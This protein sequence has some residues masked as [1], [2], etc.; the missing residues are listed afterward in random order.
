MSTATPATG[1]QKRDS[2]SGAWILDKT[3]GTW[4]MKEYLETMEVDPLAIEAH[5]KGDRE[6]DTIHT[7]EYNPPSIKIV[8]RSRVN[9]D[10]TTELELGVELVEYLN[11]GERPKRLLATSQGP[12]HLEIKST[13]QTLS[14]GVAAVTDVKQLQQEENSTIMIQNLTITNEK[15][16]KS[17]SM[18]RYF[19]PYLQ[20]PPHLVVDDAPVAT[21]KAASK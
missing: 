19:V 5:E 16:Q 21:P 2:L 7:I 6:T 14:H 15:T 3:R 12:G 18:V 9:N 20:T 13:L 17:H 8:K 11:P 10:L 1:S 4:P